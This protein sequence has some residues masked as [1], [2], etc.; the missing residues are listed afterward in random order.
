M[1]TIHRFAKTDISKNNTTDVVFPKGTKLAV[2]YTFP[3]DSFISGVGVTVEDD[4]G[5]LT[6]VCASCLTT[7]E[8]I[9]EDEPEYSLI[10]PAMKQISDELDEIAKNFI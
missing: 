1:S 3:S 2:L 8:L 9:V 6:N 4:K 7:E 5:N 10:S